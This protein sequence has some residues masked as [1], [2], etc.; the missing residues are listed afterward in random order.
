MSP[1]N[2]IR[3]WIGTKRLFR[4]F[5]QGIWVTG[6]LSLEKMCLNEEAVF[7]NITQRRLLAQVR[8]LA[9]GILFL[10][11]TAFSF[12]YIFSSRNAPVTT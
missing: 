12:E 2:Q 10:T 11:E 6:A 9:L 7:V 8:L 5:V 1:T 3:K 4:Y